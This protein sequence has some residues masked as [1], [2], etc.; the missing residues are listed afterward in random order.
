M[1]GDLTPSMLIRR[2]KHDSSPAP[3]ATVPIQKSTENR[4]V[5]QPDHR[6]VNETQGSWLHIV[7]LRHCDDGANAENVD[8]DPGD[9]ERCNHYD[10]WGLGAIREATAKT[11]NAGD[12]DQC[13]NETNQCQNCNVRR[14]LKHRQP[15]G[16]CRDENKQM[17][18]SKFHRSRDSEADVG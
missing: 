18:K 12:G 7:N 11:S 1:P 4:F 2:Q 17:S 15:T 5:V 16:A 14:S 3:S 6:S 13:R 10:P 8:G 9:R